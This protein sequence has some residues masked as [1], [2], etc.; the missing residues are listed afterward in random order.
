M[1]SLRQAVAALVISACMPAY[2]GSIRV[3]VERGGY[4]GPLEIRV[5]VPHEDGEPKWLVARRL[6]AES[7]ADVG[8]LTA[9]TYVV[10]VSGAAPFERFAISAGVR[11]EGNEVL[12]VTLP[13]PR[14]LKGAIR[15]GTGN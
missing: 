6:A 9:G 14:R 3:S 5:G 13:K 2:A 7:V 12:R 4:I 15:V 1:P 10:L 8:S 11:A